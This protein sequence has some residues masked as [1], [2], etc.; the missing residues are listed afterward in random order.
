MPGGK[1]PHTSTP[2]NL[3]ESKALGLSCVGDALCQRCGSEYNVGQGMALDRELQLTF[4]R[5]LER[6]MT[7]FVEMMTIRRLVSVPHGNKLNYT[8]PP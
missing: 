6:L 5:L 4:A 7:N 2:L 3:R 1:R 8:L